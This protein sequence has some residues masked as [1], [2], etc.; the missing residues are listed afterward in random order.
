M[1]PVDDELPSLFAPDHHH[2]E[3]I[4]NKLIEEPPYERSFSFHERFQCQKDEGKPPQVD[5]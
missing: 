3:H 5:H 4:F 1:E 2:H